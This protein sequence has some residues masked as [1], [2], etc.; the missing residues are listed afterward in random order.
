VRLGG[1]AVG[2]SGHVWDTTI[3]GSE[4]FKIGDSAIVTVG[5]FKQNDGV[6]SDKYPLRTNIHNNHF[7]EIGVGGRAVSI[8]TPG[9]VSKTARDGAQQRQPQAAAAQCLRRPR[10]APGHRQ[11]DRGAV[12]RHFLPHPLRRRPT[13]RV[14]PEPWFGVWKLYSLKKSP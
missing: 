9:A 3:S 13:S 1:N 4:F 11:A 12:L 6:S 14:D 10:A 2:I 5:D 8:S 7:H